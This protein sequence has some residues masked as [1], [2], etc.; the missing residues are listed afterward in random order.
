MGL[1][2]GPALGNLTALA[3]E[4][5]LAGEVLE[6]AFIRGSA[7]GAGGGKKEI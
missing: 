4:H 1:E 3:A 2:H 7:F 6:G 5:L